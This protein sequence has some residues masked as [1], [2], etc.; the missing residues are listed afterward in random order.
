VRQAILTNGSATAELLQ[1]GALC[2][3][4]HLNTDIKR[5]TVVCSTSVTAAASVLLPAVDA[6]PLR[7]RAV[8]MSMKVRMHSIGLD[9]LT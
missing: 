6:M 5:R 8:S 2:A 4:Q 3:H 7:E 1:L 9:S